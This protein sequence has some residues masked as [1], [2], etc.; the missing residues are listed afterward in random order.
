MSHALPPFGSDRPNV[1][2]SPQLAHPSANAWFN[3]AAFA[4]PAPFTFGNAGRNV[5]IGPSLFTMDVSVA[6]RFALF[7]RVFLTAEAQA[8]NLFNHTNFD[9]FVG[10]LK[11]PFYGKANAALPARTV[12][13]SLRY[14][15]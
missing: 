3:T 12:Q 7:E 9:H 14:S 8:F 4:I 13:A 10:V 1:I 6:R 5:L 11:S 15:W 2:G